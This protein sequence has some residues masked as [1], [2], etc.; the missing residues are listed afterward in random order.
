[1]TTTNP[2]RRGQRYRR[3]ITGVFGVAIAGY[4][5]GVLVG[6][7]LLGLVVYAVAALVGIG[8]CLFVQFGSSVSLLDERQRRLHERASHAVV[9]VLVYVGVPAWIAVFLADA[10]GQY[11][12]GPTVAGALYAFSAFAI[13]WGVAYTI[14][15][16][17]G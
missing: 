3:L 13:A 7:T 15:R 1:M 2:V 11:T 8:A 6:E 4:V 17:R 9:N 16:Y 10:T 5:A 12:I 14:V